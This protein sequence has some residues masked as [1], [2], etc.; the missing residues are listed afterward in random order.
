MSESESASQFS[1]CV[2]RLNDPLKVLEIF[3]LTNQTSLA[4]NLKD[5]VYV[6]RV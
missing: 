3:R 2:Y 6:H 5:D 4:A 1:L